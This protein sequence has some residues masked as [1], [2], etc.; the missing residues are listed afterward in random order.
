MSVDAEVAPVTT[1]EP[2]EAP[3]AVHLHVDGNLRLKTSGD[4]DAASGALASDNLGTDSYAW[5][6]EE[7]TNAFGDRS[8]AQALVAGVEAIL[9]DD[10]SQENDMLTNA[11]DMLIGE[12][13]PQ[14]IVDQLI[15]QQ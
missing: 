14:H 2:A 12:G 3:G 13:V 15:Q 10:P 8:A 4:F 7:I 5:L 11:V 1:S 9:G 6:E